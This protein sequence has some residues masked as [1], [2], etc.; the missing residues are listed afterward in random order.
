[1][2]TESWSWNQSFQDYQHWRR[3]VGDLNRW[4]LRM[5]DISA[6]CTKR[7]TSQSDAAPYIVSTT[8]GSN[9]GPETDKSHPAK[10][11][12]DEWELL[13][14]WSELVSL[15]SLLVK[16]RQ[17][18]VPCL[19]D[20]PFDFNTTASIISLKSRSFFEISTRQSS[21]FT[22]TCQESDKFSIRWFTVS[23]KT[24]FIRL[25]GFQA[26]IYDQ[27]CCEI[28]SQCI[29]TTSTWQHQS[30]IQCF[31]NENWIWTASFYWVNGYFLSSECCAHIA[32]RHDESLNKQ[33][34]RCWLQDAKCIW[35]VQCIHL[36]QCQPIISWHAYRSWQSEWNETWIMA[37]R[38][39]FKTKTKRITLLPN[40][41]HPLHVCSFRFIKIRIME[42]GWW[43]RRW[44]WSWQNYTVSKSCVGSIPTLL[45]LTKKLLLAA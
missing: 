45:E 42:G 40:H 26:T 44:L 25:F 21:Y 32:P 27:T 36:P 17:P 37:P 14:M 19:G 34:T 12:G 13:V 7:H 29:H 11:R 39:K 20:L 22:T 4:K 38:L 33:D 24:R 23:L 15:R 1:M 30:L 10:L 18:R 35:N 6:I 5:G 31:E 16:P 8:T 2:W 3:C 43:W 9:C 41:T 28:C